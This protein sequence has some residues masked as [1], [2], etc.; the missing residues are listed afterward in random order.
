MRADR[1]RKVSCS[2]RFYQHRTA[3]TATRRNTATVS[4]AAVTAETDPDA[5][6]Q[7]VSQERAYEQNYRRIAASSDAAY[8]NAVQAKHVGP[9]DLP[10][11]APEL[12]SELATVGC[13]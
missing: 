6:T 2:S 7:R 1:R 13:R 10:H 9:T 5:R 8:D 11:A 4:R 12:D 3:C